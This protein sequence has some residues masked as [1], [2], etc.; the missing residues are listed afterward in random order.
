MDWLSTGTR[1]RLLTGRRLL[2]VALPA[3]ALIGATSERRRLGHL[4]KGHAVA[5][6]DD[7]EDGD[8]DIFIQMGGATNGDQYHNIL[9]QNP[10]QANHWL[11]V[12]LVGTKANWAA[13]GARIKVVTAGEKP[14]TIHRHLSSG[15]SFGAS[16]FGR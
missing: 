6:G 5:C 9:F 14:L 2:V 3:A 16:P 4:Q 13:I 10:G 8:L 12:K 1:R 7:D 15:G 11:T